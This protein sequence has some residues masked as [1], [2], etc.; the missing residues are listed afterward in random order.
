MDPEFALNF[1][2]K[3]LSDMIKKYGLFRGIQAY[4]TPGAIGSE[5]LVNYANKILQK[6]GY[7]INIVSGNK[8][9]QPSKIKASP[10]LSAPIKKKK[11]SFEYVSCMQDLSI[12]DKTECGTPPK[13]F[14]K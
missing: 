4:N 9:A 7:D 2:A 10:T 11:T 8:Q 3:R 5:F 13:T 1:V 14:E 12:Q 6:A